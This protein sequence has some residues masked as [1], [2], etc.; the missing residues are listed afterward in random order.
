MR[1]SVWRPPGGWRAALRVLARGVGGVLRLPPAEWATT[2]RAIVVIVFV[3]VLVRPIPLDRLARLLGVRVDLTPS[4]TVKAKLPLRELPGRARRQIR[5]ARRV[6]RAWPFSD[7]PCL[8]ESLVTGHLLRRHAPALRIGVGK[9]GDNLLAHAWL[10]I[11]GRP[12]EH[13]VGLAAFQ[14]Q[15]RPSG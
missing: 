1:G 5:C 10:E 11:G 9:D 14:R 12:L 8:R 7:G 13:V 15:T 6:A 4:A 2:A 3:E